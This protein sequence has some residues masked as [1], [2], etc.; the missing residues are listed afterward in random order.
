[1]RNKLFISTIAAAGVAFSGA[2]MAADQGSIGGTAGAPYN[3]RVGSTG[4][5]VIT[6]SIPKL[7]RI[8]D[9]ADI[10]LTLPSAGDN[11][12]T[13]GVSGT[14]PACV[15]Q[16]GSNAQ[17]TLMA[18]SSVAGASSFKLTDG[19]NFVDYSVTWGGAAVGYNTATAAQTPESTTLGSCTA[20][21]DKLAVSI[22]Q[23]DLNAAEGSATNYSDTLVLLVT[24][25]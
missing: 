7:I 8:S 22:T 10:T 5:S 18:T 21:S 15:R 12:Y 20:V 24:P 3:T 2:S 17:Y 13:A 16:N 19:T 1:M 9:L 6:A 25:I 14:S 4:N 23:S 11:G